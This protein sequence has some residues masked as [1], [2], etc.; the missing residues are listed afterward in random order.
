MPDNSWQWVCKRTTFEE[1]GLRLIEVK[2]KCTSLLRKRV[3]ELC[4]AD[5]LLFQQWQNIIV[6]HLDTESWIS[7]F[8]EHV[9]GDDRILGDHRRP[10]FFP[11]FAKNGIMTPVDLADRAKPECFCRSKLLT[12][13]LH[14]E[15]WTL[16]VF[17]LTLTVQ[18]VK[19]GSPY[20]Q[21]IRNLRPG[22]ILSLNCLN[23]ILFKLINRI[24][25]KG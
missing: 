3:S 17:T 13:R 25:Q 5:Q 19:T 18:F 11:S 15:P 2:S 10:M 6:E 16:D 1:W 14:Q 20:Q 24:R 23:S 7:A 9:C 12:P 22:P 4:N 21:A 8:L